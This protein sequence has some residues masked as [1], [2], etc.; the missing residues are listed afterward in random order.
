M[1]IAWK[2]VTFFAVYK[3]LLPDLIFAYPMSQLINSQ[4]SLFVCSFVFLAFLTPIY[5]VHD[6]ITIT[7][8]AFV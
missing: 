7:A 5:D 2:T 8:P 4:L 6:Y 1:C 3:N